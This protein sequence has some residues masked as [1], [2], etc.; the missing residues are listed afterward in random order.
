MNTRVIKS[1]YVTA[2]N[3]MFKNVV[4]EAFEAAL[5]SLCPV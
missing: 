5:D 3:E 2:Y 4:M 1:V